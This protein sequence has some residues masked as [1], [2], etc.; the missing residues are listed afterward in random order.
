MKKIFIIAIACLGNYFA[1][2]QQGWEV[3]GGIGVS[4]YF[5]DLN[6]SN[7]LNAPHLAASV[8][9]RYN[10]NNRLCVKASANIATVSAA[11]KNSKNTY[12]RQ[13]N[14]DFKS[15]IFDG[16]VQFEFNFLPYTHGSNNDFFTPYAL[17]GFSIFKFNPTTQYQGK[18][19]QLRSLG[20]EGQFLNSEYFGTA[21]AF[22]YGGG[23]KVDVTDKWSV[24]VELAMRQTFTDYLDDVSGV[25]PNM[26]ELKK[27][28]GQ[29]AVDLSDRSIPNA[30]G[31]KL[32]TRGLQRGNSQ[33]N[34]SYG[35]L[36]V[37]MVYYFGDLK[38]P[39]FLK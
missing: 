6:T 25:Y 21:S 28:H 29:L 20:T 1:T 9:G 4:H 3:G 16:S 12:E 26:K 31:S 19:V 15:R 14:L 5:G 32:G 17:A 7:R 10:F 38:C 24:N 37:G 22:L 2:A 13:R 8:V 23:I 27:T 39:E 36:T 30:D 35:L 34:D 18:T 33:N 11:D